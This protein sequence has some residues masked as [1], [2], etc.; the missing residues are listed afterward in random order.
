MNINFQVHCFFCLYFF[1]FFLYNK[2]R[3]FVYH[4]IDIFIIKKSFDFLKGISLQ[5]F[6][7]IDQLVWRKVY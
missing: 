5:N 2:D 3:L 7:H 6:L 4:Q 1:F